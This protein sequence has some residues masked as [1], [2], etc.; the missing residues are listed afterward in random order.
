MVNMPTFSMVK[1]SERPEFTSA[2]LTLIEESFDYH[3]PESY[4]N[5]FFPLMREENSHHR[6]LLL[7]DNKELVG[8]IAVKQKNIFHHH[9]QSDVIFIGGIAVKESERGQGHFNTLLEH[10]KETYHKNVSLMVLWSDKNEMYAKHGFEL[11]IGQIQVTGETPLSGWE[12]TKY[13]ELSFEEKKRIKH[14]YYLTAEDHLFTVKRDEE[15]WK[16]TEA[17]NGT[18][19]YLK[20][21]KEKI[22]AYFFQSKGKDLPNI[23]HEFGVEEEKYIKDMVQTTPFTFWL[24]E[25]YLT[26]FPE[27]QVQYGSLVRIASHSL[28]KE[29]IHYWSD[30]EIAI[31]KILKDQ[32]YFIFNQ[33]SF[34]L[35]H[36]EF[37]SS[38]F[39]PYP[40]KEF[41]HF[42]KNF[43]ISGL[44][45]I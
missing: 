38:L 29:L 41:Q 21:S 36:Q 10:V 6:Y 40:L 27:A 9:F 33:E 42:N 1:L 19:L 26:L 35:G 32:V 37:L 43:F 34:N 45:S 18:D 39:G 28:F 2:S 15:A 22:V 13:K 31:E 3:S 25:K 4:A 44:D 7:K 11:C 12:K 14:L 17:I 5:D 30:G 23:C 20:R 8:H 24:P 16:E